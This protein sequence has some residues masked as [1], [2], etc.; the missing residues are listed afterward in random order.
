MVPN[1]R[2]L[3]C[4]NLYLYVA[5]RL[6]D[7]CTSKPKICSQYKK[8]NFSSILVHFKISWTPKIGLGFENLKP[9]IFEFSG[10]KSASTKWWDYFKK[11]RISVTWHFYK[12]YFLFF[13]IFFAKNWISWLILEISLGAVFILVDSP[14]NSW[15]TLR[16]QVQHS[17]LFIRCS[18]FF[19]NVIFKLRRKLKIARIFTNNVFYLKVTE[20]VHFSKFNS[21]IS[22]FFLIKRFSNHHKL[23]ILRLN[24]KTTQTLTCQKSFKKLT[25][26]LPI[27]HRFSLKEHYFSWNVFLKKIKFRVKLGR[28]R[29][30]TRKAESTFL[31]KIGAFVLNENLEEYRTHINF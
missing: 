29:K 21:M 13:S 9:L 12:F 1:F 5:T 8:E 23:F 28:S 24:I 16:F 2:G 18:D 14:Q 20:N 25:F 27:K 3:I 10:S 31:A 26:L 11:M 6:A 15:S 19:C 22:C 30:G 4:Q 7:T 17:L